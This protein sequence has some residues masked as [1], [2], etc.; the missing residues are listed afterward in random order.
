MILRMGITMKFHEKLQTLRKEKGLSQEQLAETLDVSR[1]AVSKWE[2]GQSYPEIEKLVAL[3]DLLGVT[4]DRLVRDGDLCAD[5]DLCPAAVSDMSVP[6]WRN[7]GHYEYKSKRA[8][9]GLPLVHIN[10]GGRGR[11]AKGIIAIGDVATGVVAVGLA[12]AGAVSIGVASAGLLGLGVV[13]VGA[14]LSVGSLAFGTVA[15]GAIAVGVFTFG[16]LSL[17]MFSV[18]AVSVASHIAVGD[19][20]SG[21][22]AI[23]ETV[24]GIKTI[25]LASSSQIFSEVS[26]SEVRALISSEFTGIWKG[27]ANMFAGIFRG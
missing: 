14:L 4:L 5:S 8:L 12:A 24:N 1:Q 23:G 15:I 27:A 20:A 2:S 13:S 10:V 17:G 7:G 25:K 16:A 6:L 19:Y 22:I 11:R 26:A 9:C 3:C 21:H 18:G